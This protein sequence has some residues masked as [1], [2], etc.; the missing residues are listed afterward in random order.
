MNGWIKVYRELLNKPIWFESTPKQKTILITILLMA[1]NQER[2]WEWHGKQ[3]HASPGE[4]ITSLKGIAQQAGVGINEGNVR[5]ALKRFESY[6]FLTCKST[7]KNRL[8]NIVNW[9]KYQDSQSREYKQKHKQSTSNVQAEYKQNTTNEELK[10]LRTKE[11]KNK[12]NVEKRSSDQL[13][14]QVH[15][16]ILY[17]NS[18]ASKHFRANSKDTA[19]LISGRLHDGFTVDDFKKVIDIKTPQWV[20]TDYDKFLRPSTL[21]APNHFE[22]YLNERPIKQKE[23]SQHDDT[24]RDF[25]GSTR[26]RHEA[27][28]EPIRTPQKG[29]EPF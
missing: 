5:T 16:I 7:N 12:D 11:L 2:Q 27:K 29:D 3:Y 10:N 17:L 1:N 20:G 18:Q 19:K 24:S 9:H 23:L 25:G 13:K 26:Y 21:F 6:R 15:E 8:I 14:G 4:L 28:P 22:S